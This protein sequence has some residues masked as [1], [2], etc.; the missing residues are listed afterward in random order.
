MSKSYSVLDQNE[1]VSFSLRPE[2]DALVAVL[3]NPNYI[4]NIGTVI[5]NVNALGVDALL[6]VD[7]LNRLDADIS[8]LR[9]RKSLLKY[10]NGA[11]KWTNVK[12]FETVEQCFSFLEEHQF[13]SVGTSPHHICNKQ[14]KL[15]DSK[16]AHQRLAI[17]FGEESKGLS[18]EV[19]EGCEY[20]L[21]I[22][23]KGRVESLNLS[24][25]TGIVLHEA[26]RQRSKQAG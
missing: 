14:V 2:G 17:W 4:R 10:S 12:R 16:L 22:E 6:V 18:E 23:M 20:C 13:V 9:Q 19:A 7:N 24:T 15:S 11:V 8:E 1:D 26:V 5:R 3:E 25:T 21:T